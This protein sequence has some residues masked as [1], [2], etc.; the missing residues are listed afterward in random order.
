[1]E[2]VLVHIKNLTELAGVSGSEDNVRAYIKEKIRQYVDNITVDSI[3][4]LIAYKKGRSSKLKVMLAAHMDEVGFLVSGYTDAGYIKFKKVGGIDDRI[5]PGKRVLLGDKKIPGVIGSKAIH[6]QN[7][8][9]FESNV[10]L[11]KMYIDIGCDKK[12]EAEAL[13]PLGEYIVFN[14]QYSELE[15]DSIKAKALDDRA[16]CAV[17]M[18][19]L[20]NT[21][22]FDLYGCFT[23]QEEVGLRGA[24]VAA[25]AVN[26]DIAV[27]IESTTCS[28]VSDVEEYDYSTIYGEG[29]AI[30][31]MDKTTLYDRN[32]VDFIYNIAI[33]NNIKVQ[34]KKTVS[35]GNDAGPIQRTREGV[36]VATI[37][38][39]CRYIHS[40]V[41]LINKNDLFSCLNIMKLFLKQIKDCPGLK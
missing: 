5:L 21:Y 4:N 24:E 1:M 35:G 18:E 38:I 14:T 6:M 7:D 23:V 26:P 16:G 25:Y 37:S 22:D 32:L 3:G 8:D 9:E 34:L 13:A 2:D 41:S 20:K 27:I 31:L 30:S 39:P 36:K 28:D 12:D 29:A 15:G 17:I 11:E 33:K 40:P 10:K 19:L